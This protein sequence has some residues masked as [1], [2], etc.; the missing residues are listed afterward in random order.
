ML[1]KNRRKNQ[2]G[3]SLSEYALILSI[4]AVGAVFGLQQ[5][6]GALSTTLGQSGSALVNALTAEDGNIDDGD[7][8]TG[9][10]QPGNSGNTNNNG[11]KKGHDKDNNGKG[12][13]ANK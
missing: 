7:D 2:R 8:T 6:Q 10:D 5:L 1:M 4:A 9:G 11:K 12:K 13:G 3:Q